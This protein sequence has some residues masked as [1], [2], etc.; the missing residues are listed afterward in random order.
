MLWGQQLMHTQMHTVFTS[1]VCLCTQG[2]GKTGNCPVEA[3][4]NK[5]RM[6]LHPLRNQQQKY[7]C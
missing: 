6:L 2:Y 4:L 7:Q 1:S 5:Q 3:C